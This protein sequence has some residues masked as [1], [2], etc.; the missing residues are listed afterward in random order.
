M[1]RLAWTKF[2]DFYLRPGFLKVL[3]AGLSPDRRSAP[4]EAI[5]RR[6]ERPLFDDAELHQQLWATVGG[7]LKIP[8]RLSK[9]KPV[10]KKP[11]KEPKPSVAEALLLDGDCPS[12]LFAITGPT[13]YKIL[14]WGR[15]VEFT[16]RG[17]QITERGLLLRHLLDSS[18]IELFLSGTVEAWN[19]FVLT[20]EE[21]LFF[22]YHLAEIDGVI[23]ELIKDLG[24]LPEGHVLESSE[25]ARMTARAL[26]RVLT[27]A[28]N[29]V[30]PRDVLSFRIACN[31]A[32]TIAEELGI[33]DE[34]LPLVGSQRRKS[35][36]PVSPAARA[37]RGA[38]RGRSARR[39][40][41][42]ADHQTIPRFEQLVDL[43]FL[44]KPGHDAPIPAHRQSA[45]ERWRYMPTDACRRWLRGL[46]S[47]QDE[48]I[49]FLWN[50]FARACLDALDMQART[51]GPPNSQTIVEY[52]W[53][54]YK[55]VHRRA[56]PNP[57]D[58]VALYA[59]ILAITEG[60]RI[61]MED[62]HRV[63]LEIK[64]QNLLPDHAFFASGND[65][66]QMF[67]Q[68][69]PGFFEQFLRSQ[70]QVGAQ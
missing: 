59:M 44:V 38:L 63:M 5:V 67:I 2:Q 34:A 49:P 6:L 27:K 29:R 41:K 4:N 10:D 64:R 47:A 62:V 31:L 55:H 68:L 52:V 3:V 45:R 40:T 70:P 19:P 24:Q 23:V 11:K 36:R 57:L 20:L 58:S 25:A 35:P 53:R 1:R 66:D 50:G 9:A 17:N 13:A 46:Q 56:G 26:V 28:Q 15:D 21:R 18:R 37:A 8:N 65:L 54:A 30:Q 16:G 48:R 61:E 60:V 7:Q 22:L 32:A 42:N 14:D 69:R 12:L 33:S 43:G 51:G 39:T